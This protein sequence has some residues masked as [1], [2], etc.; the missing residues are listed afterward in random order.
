MLSMTHAVF[1]LWHVK[2]SA[3]KN[4]HC[5]KQDVPLRIVVRMAASGTVWSSDSESKMVIWWSETHES[6][7]QPVLNH[8]DKWCVTY[9]LSVI[10][11]LQE[12]TVEFRGFCSLHSKNIFNPDEEA[13]FNV[14][15]QLPTTNRDVSS[16]NKLLHT[17][18][19]HFQTVET[20]HVC[21]WRV[22]FCLNISPVFVWTLGG[23]QTMH[24]IE[25]VRV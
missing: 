19:Q 13:V 9:R 11:T 12:E 7:K 20:N 25:Y 24:R 1:L 22:K 3:V 23:S 8:T 6:N 5:L 18:Q 15:I 4:V 2:M 16:S 21:C 17:V 14:S 10:H